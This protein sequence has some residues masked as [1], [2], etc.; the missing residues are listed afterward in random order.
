[1]QDLLS[2]ESATVVEMPSSVLKPVSYSGN[3]SPEMTMDACDKKL[4]T[5][6]QSDV[7]AVPYCLLDLSMNFMTFPHISLHIL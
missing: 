1:M 2:A 5:S 4:M 7:S 3:K 6:V